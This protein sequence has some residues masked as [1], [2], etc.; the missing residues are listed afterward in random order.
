MNTVL[1][2]GIADFFVVNLF[3]RRISLPRNCVNKTSL[4]QNKCM[5]VLRRLARHEL[6]LRPNIQANG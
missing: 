3:L 5:F 1:I 4:L 6:F 2:D